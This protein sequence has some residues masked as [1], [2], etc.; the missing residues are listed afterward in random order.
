MTAD[1]YATAFMMMGLEKSKEFLSAN[2][3]LGLEVFFV[4]DE[5][6]S[7]KTYA[8]DRMRNWMHDVP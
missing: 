4:Y 5:N 7:W 1:A 3:Q 2:K 8:S 6:G